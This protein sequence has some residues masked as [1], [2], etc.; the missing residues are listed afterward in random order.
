MGV[1]A[2]KYGRSYGESYGLNLK[3]ASNSYGRSEGLFLILVLVVS[4]YCLLSCYHRGLIHAL[5]MVYSNRGEL[6]SA[7]RAART[8]VVRDVREGPGR[9]E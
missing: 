1:R 8:V 5:P 2:Q 6:L 3:D 4:R 9:G 7:A